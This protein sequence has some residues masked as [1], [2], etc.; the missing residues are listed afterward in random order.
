M[1]QEPFEQERVSAPQEDQAV[2]IPEVNASA[3]MKLPTYSEDHDWTPG[4]LQK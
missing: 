4:C 1:A 3:R 2:E